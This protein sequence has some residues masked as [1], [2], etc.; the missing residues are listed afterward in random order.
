MDILYSSMYIYIYGYMDTLYIIFKDNEHTILLY[1]W[2]YGYNMKYLRI[3]GIL[4]S[5]IN[6]YMDII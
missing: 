1:K 6:G 4:Y 2:I 5:Y 3:M